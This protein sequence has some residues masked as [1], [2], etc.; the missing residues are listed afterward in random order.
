MLSARRPYSEVAVPAS[1]FVA[2]EGN[3]AVVDEGEAVG[4]AMGAAAVG[5]GSLACTVL[6]DPSRSALITAPSASARPT[7]AAA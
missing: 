7:A 5:S 6:A 1:P 2:D 4:A 3:N